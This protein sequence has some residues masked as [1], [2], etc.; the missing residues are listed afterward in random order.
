ME[1]ID[2]YN[3]PA[4]LAPSGDVNN[5]VNPDSQQ[6]GLIVA[7]ACCLILTTIF[8]SIRISTKAFVLRAVRIEDCRSF[9]RLVT[10]LY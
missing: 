10:E 9:S 4:M 6:T 7:A 5:L 8:A 3:T 2:I 1:N